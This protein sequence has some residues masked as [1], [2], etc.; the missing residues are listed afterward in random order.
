MDLVYIFFW[1][2]FCVGVIVGVIGSVI[3]CFMDVIKICLMLL[4]LGNQWEYRY[5]FY[6]FQVIVLN[7]GICGFWIG[8]S[9]IV[10]CLV[11]VLVIVV[12]LYDYVK[13]II[14]NVEL[15]S[16]GFV[17]YIVVFFIVGFV[18]NCVMLFIDMVC[19]RYMNQKKDYNK[20]LV[21]YRGIIDCIMKIVCKEG[22]FGFYKGF[23]LNWIRIGIYMVV[24][25]FVFE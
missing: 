19:I 2:K 5:M 18:I 15:L 17:L 25:F 3:V 16:E 1:K 20:K 8:V 21:L 7:E 4:F 9:V 12:L 23:I 6:V 10:K 14:L 11:F 13:Y 22:L 24:I